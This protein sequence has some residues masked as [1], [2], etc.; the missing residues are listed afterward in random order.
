MTQKS[1]KESET[2]ISVTLMMMVHP[3]LRSLFLDVFRR[4]VLF[5]KRTDDSHKRVLLSEYNPPCRPSDRRQRPCATVLRLNRLSNFCGMSP[6]AS[7]AQP[8]TDLFIRCNLQPCSKC[9]PPSLRGLWTR[10]RI[11]LRHGPV[12]QMQ[13]TKHARCSRH[14]MRMGRSVHSLTHPSRLARTHP[15]CTRPPNASSFRSPRPRHRRPH[16]S[17]WTC[18]PDASEDACPKRLAVRQK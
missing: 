4:D 17:S 7:G 1:R 18:S 16:V 8:E 3:Y 14:A 13:V 10:P 9:P 6:S 15:P 12:H 2:K 5:I 11:S